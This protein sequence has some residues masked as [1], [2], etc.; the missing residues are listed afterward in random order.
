MRALEG[1]EDC[2]VNLGAVEGTIARVELPRVAKVVEGILEGGLG[3]VPRLDIAKKLLGARGEVELKRKAKRAVHVGEKVEAALNLLVDLLG[4]AEDVGVILLEAA[5]TREAREGAGKLVAVEDAKVGK[6]K[7]ELLVGAVAVLEDEAVS[8]AVHGL[9]GKRLLLALK[10]EHVLRVVGPVARRLPELAVENVGGDDLLEAAHLVLAADKVDERVVD[11]GA[12]GREKAA[13]GAEV[14][15]E[16]ELLVAA[17]LAVVALC[18]LLLDDLPLLE[19]LRV[20]K[21]DAI[22]ALERLGLGLA[23][24]VRRGGLCDLEGL[25]LA[26][27]ADMGAA[28]QIN[29]G[30]IAVHRRAV[31]RNLLV[32]DAQLELVVGKHLA[33]VLL[34]DDKALVLLLLLDGCLHQGL[35]LLVV[36]IAENVAVI[37]KRVVVEAVGNGWAIAQ[38]AAL[39]ELHC[40]AKHVGRRV[41]ED[42]LALGVVKLEKLNVAVALEDAV[43]VPQLAV[44]LG[45]DG[46]VGQALADQAGNIVGR[47]A[48]RLAV[49][50]LAIGE[51]D[52]DGAGLLG[53][54][55]GLLLGVELL[56]E[57]DALIEVRRAWVAQ[58]R[59]QDLL[60]ALFLLVLGLLV[61][62]LLLLLLLLGRCVRHGAV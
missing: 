57:L 26:R 21:G 18:G 3:A 8:R 53:S 4:E 43:E 28:A 24:P 45:D 12:V 35:E 30:T 60:L 50:H 55:L 2:D 7:R 62:G 58:E 22:D 15:E 13:A 20:G 14:V 33:Q 29:E 32:D 44:D 48:P 56:K 17:N 61:L 46:V 19:E 51:G 10:L 11:V 34:G 16:K 25:D 52:L 36:L 38:A 27:V 23:L 49:K 1:V 37:E 5:D 47:R 40:L 41:P 39:V 42:L 9:E 54:N 59:R 6:A 31:R